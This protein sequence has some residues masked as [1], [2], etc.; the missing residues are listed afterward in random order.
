MM[1][2][3]RLIGGLALPWL[4]GIAI[5]LALRDARRPLT[6]PGEIA[7][8]VGAGYLGGAIVLTLWMRVLSLAGIR[9]GVLSIALPLVLATLVLGYLGGRRCG[10]TS[11]AAP[12]RSALSALMMP[13]E[14]GGAARLLWQLALAWLAF[15]YVVLGLL[16]EW[17]PL[18][19][20][21]AWI[22]WATKAR[23]WYEEGRLAPFQGGAAWFAA[24]G[25]AWTDA[26]PGYP[27]TMPLLQ[28][29]TCIAL[30]RW[31]DS[32]MNWPWWQISVALTLAV[33]GGLRSLEVPALGSLVGAFLVATLPLANVHVALAGYADLPMAAYYTAA[34]LAVLRWTRL[35][36]P[37]RATLAIVLAAA[38][39]QIKVPGIVWALTLVPGSVV[40]LLPRHGLKLTVIGAGAAL[41]ALA[42]LAQTH[43]IIF[44]YQLHLDFAPP[45]NAIAETHFLLANWNLLWYG[46]LAAAFLAWRRLA[47][48]QLAPMTAIVAADTLFLFVVFSFA[49]PR[50]WMT[51]QTTINRA[52]LHA[53]PIAC[54]FV[55]LAYQAFAAH[56]TAART[57]APSAVA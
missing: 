54:L 32:L 34:A 12:V 39:T 30:G 49:G 57:Q 31:D 20:W 45:W 27:P 4:L 53:A 38:C 35:R 13:L 43:P 10:D 55:V 11:I 56:W 14:L 6:A 51:E 47:S 41:F 33:Y 8:L 50:A 48:D 1:D 52:T 40:A 42:V 37:R 46:A 26:A 21:D 16:V 2:T 17:Q 3:V 29:W 18:Y 5:L 9:F 23:V 36:G 15:R 25:A 7:W 28:A 24:G 44:N 22:E 19:P